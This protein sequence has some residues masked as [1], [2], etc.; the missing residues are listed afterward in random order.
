MRENRASVCRMYARYR[1]W[2]MWRGDEDAGI[3]ILDIG[4]WIL[5]VDG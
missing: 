2:V 4:C 5:G 3:W 1:C